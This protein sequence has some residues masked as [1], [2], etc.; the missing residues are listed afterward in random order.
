[1]PVVPAISQLVNYDLAVSLP[2]YAQII[3]TPETAFFGINRAGDLEGDCEKI[4]LK[5]DR[6]M[7]ARYLSEAQNEIEEET[8]FPLHPKWFTYEE[9]PYAYPVTTRW[10]KVI[11]VGFHA[12]SVIASDEAVD[13]TNDPAVIGPFA[14]TIT[15]EDEVRVFHPGLDVEIMPSK[16]TLTGV[17]ATIEIP[18]ARLVT[19]E[20]SENPSTGHTYTDTGPT[21]PFEQTVDVYRIFTSDRIHATLKWPHACSGGGCC[22]CGDN[23]QSACMYV[24]NHENGTITTL[25]SNYVPQLDD[26][27]IE[28]ED[29]TGFILLENAEMPEFEGWRASCYRCNGKPTVMEINYKAGLNPTTFQAEDAIIRLAHSKM[30]HAPCGCDF[31][32]NMWT[33]DRNVPPVLTKERL[34]CPFGMSDGAWIA[35]RFTQAMRSIGLGII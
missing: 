19:E 27:L 34:N 16:I 26:Y 30:P 8:G 35:Y 25:P 3:K 6:E 13:H 7:I 11:E 23:Q 2:R 18:R 9:H 5:E 10:K 29:Q 24:I 12:S 33:R 32:M 4:W 20:D 21:G 31:A 15:E 22:T 14:C 28:L 1:M 17:Q